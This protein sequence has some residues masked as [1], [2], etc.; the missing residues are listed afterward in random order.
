MEK[1]KAPGEVLLSLSGSWEDDRPAEEIN[2]E[3]RSAHRQLAQ[4]RR[5]LM[6]LLDTDIII[7]SL[8]GRT[9]VMAHLEKHARSPMAM[10]VISLMEL[11]FG[12]HRSRQAESNLARVRTLEHSFRIVAADG[13]IAATFGNL[14]ARMAAAGT[15]LDDFDLIIA[16]TALAYNLTLVSNNERHFGRIEGLKL[17]NWAED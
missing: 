4:G 2:A 10:S 9:D 5:A 13:A 11:Y 7:S 14:K 6:F 1:A 16:S 8:K 17:V 15:M 3:I 12:A